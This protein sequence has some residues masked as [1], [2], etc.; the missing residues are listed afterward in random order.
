MLRHQKARGVEVYRNFSG[1]KYHPC[2]PGSTVTKNIVEQHARH[3]DSLQ[4]HTTADANPHTGK[5]NLFEEFGITLGCRN[6]KR[7]QE[8]N[9]AKCEPGAKS[10]I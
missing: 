6:D 9:Y 8:Q 2:S 1:L 7:E 5:R 3:H 10:D 4:R